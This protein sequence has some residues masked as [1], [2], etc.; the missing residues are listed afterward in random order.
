[1]CPP[2]ATPP[3]FHKWQVARGDISRRSPRVELDP[4]ATAA[5]RARRSHRLPRPSWPFC[6]VLPCCVVP[7][8]CARPGPAVSFSLAAFFC[9]AASSVCPPALLRRAVPCCVLLR[10]PALLR[11]A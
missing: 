7:A 1:M 9:A 2:T 8:L 10:P 5:R 4:T 3:P 6:V 11:R